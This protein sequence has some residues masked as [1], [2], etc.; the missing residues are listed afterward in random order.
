MFFLLCS[1]LPVFSVEKDLKYYDD[2]IKTGIESIKD[3]DYSRALELLTEAKVVAENNNWNYQL[4]LAVN[5]IGIIHSEL[6][7]YGEAL[8]YFLEAY[9]ISLKEHNKHIEMSALI[10]I[11]I[12]YYKEGNSGKAIEYL[13]KVYEDAVTRND[14]VIIGIS[15]T[16]L[17]I[18]HNKEE[19][20]DPASHYIQIAI[21]LLKNDTLS[22]HHSMVAQAENAFL[23]N[24][25]DKAK[26]LAFEILPDISDAKNREHR[27]SIYLLLSKI[28]NLEGNVHKS[29]EYLNTAI[30]ENPDIKT[31]LEIYQQ[32]ADIY[33]R[34]KQYDVAFL[35][36]DSVVFA[37]DSLNKITNL[38]HFENNRIKFEMA[39]YQK[40]LLLSKEKIV[41]ERIFFVL[42]LIIAVIL[43]WAI[44]NSSAKERQ[45]KVIAEWNQKII[46]LELEQEKN[47]KLLLERQL[48]EK[49][50]LA[51]LE[52]ERFNNEQEALKNEIEAKNRE[53]VT[54]A[55]YISSKNE[56]INEIYNSLLNLPDASIKHDLLKYMEQLKSQ[57]KNESGWGN[58]LLYFEEVNQ[59]FINSLRQKHP[60]LSS[61]DIRFLS[62]IYIGLNTKEIAS[63]LN[64]TV[65]S[66]KKKKMRVSQKLNLSGG[67]SS[68]YSYLSSL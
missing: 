62:Y 25:L 30:E 67:S 47:S 11:G 7:N 3:K 12:M 4:F 29:I 55:M 51:L 5:G 66:C 43:I 22:L 14:S 52:Q 35:Y 41:K 57:I 9:K 60:G 20:L 23:R 59:D 45:K 64:I 16:N 68:L 36:K 1:F 61:N 53:L 15:A 63:L 19:N 32:A 18:I 33:F 6:L 24:D 49:E 39:N 26:L 8:D 50:A 28:Y 58:F 27:I 40:D 38:L 2:I 34:N 42:V 31:R 46:A 44:Y 37:K 21:D 10:N 13:K 48:R 56:L 54:K 65:D 17:G